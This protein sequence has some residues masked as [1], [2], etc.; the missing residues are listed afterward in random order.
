MS[1]VY[2]RQVLSSMIFAGISGSAV[3]DTAGVSGMFMP[4]MVRKGYSKNF[5]VAV[6]AISST[7]KRISLIPRM[8]SCIRRS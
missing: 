8:Q 4:E 7:M 1:D 3:A 6:T 2:K 5:T